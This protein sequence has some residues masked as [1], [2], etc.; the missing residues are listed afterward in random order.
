MFP[1]SIFGKALLHLKQ[2]CWMSPWVVVENIPSS[3]KKIDIDIHHVYMRNNSLNNVNSCVKMHPMS[4]IN[5]EKEHWVELELKPFTR[6]R[7]QPSDVHVTEPLTTVTLPED[8][9]ETVGTHYA[10]CVQI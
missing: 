2:V 9:A 6:S 5:G 8:A 4:T 10:I 3:W 1:N 7:N